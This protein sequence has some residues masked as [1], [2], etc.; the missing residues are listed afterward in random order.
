M[1]LKPILIASLLLICIC[2]AQTTRA[3][4][5][6]LNLRD[7]GAVGDGVADDGPALQAALDALAAGGG[8][9]LFVPEGHYAIITPVAKDF[10]GASSITIFGVE[11]STPV[12]INGGGEE[13][14]SGLDLVSEFLPQTG[15]EVI[16]VSISGVRTFLIHDLAFVGNPNVES[17]ALVTLDLARIDSATISHCEFYGLCTINSGGAIVRAVR[18]VLKLEH[19]KFL[20]STG[21]SGLYAPVV[22]NLHWKGISVT[23]CVF[24]DYG[25]RPDQWGKLGDSTPLSWI[26]IGN[27]D[28][29]TNDSPRREVS[30][31][32]V[33][34]DEGAYIG[35]TVNPDFY[36]PS[37]PVDLFYVSGLRM[38]VSNLG[39]A[40]NY[41]GGIQGMLIE[42][43]TYGRNQNASSAVYIANV[44][45]AIL[46]RLACTDAASTIFAD[47]ATDKLTVIDSVYDDLN[48]QAQSTTIINSTTPDGDPVAYVRSRYQST[49][50]HG[51]DAAGHYYWS[52][53]ILSCGDDAQCIAARHA[54]LQAFL[55]SSPA[56]T[57]SISGQV[58]DEQGAP[59]AGVMV[60]L[61]GSQAVSTQTNADGRYVFSNLPT[62]G[63]YTV[64]PSANYGF[65]VPAVTVVTPAGDETVDFMA[66]ANGYAISGRVTNASGDGIAGAN[67]NLSGGQN[68]ATISDANGSYS[69]TGL[70]AG[71]DYSVAVSRVNYSFLPDTLSFVQLQSNQ[72]ANFAGAVVNYTIGGR[73]TKNGYPF[74]NAT[75]TMS[76][77]QN[78]FVKTDATGQYSFNVP[79]EQSYLITPSD[80]NYTFAPSS[81]AISNLSSNQTADFS[82]Q[83]NWGAPVLISEENSTR[84]IALD[85]VLNTTE[86]FDLTYALPW[87]TD[88]RT[89]L[90]VF[91]NNFELLPNEN[92]AAITADVQDAQ[93]HIYNL[94]VE[95]IDSP[96]GMDW[97]NRIVL[98]LPDDLGDVGDV[99][100]RITY[101]GVSSN[102]VRVAIDHV[103]GGPPDD[104][105]AVP[106]P[107]T[108]PN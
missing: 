98:R 42:N 85:C 76:G 44:R 92:V 61:S 94:T 72:T 22:E 63:V 33:F 68:A 19:S 52:E 65:N 34:L 46:D 74:V 23:N 86:P 45:Q 78:F 14:S 101:H 1:R 105:G 25:G 82:A 9:S 37:A 71:K 38:N 66:I 36:P 95:Y 83:I 35:I 32:D 102:R 27:A 12:N 17:D 3:Q 4:T 70:T 15:A 90:K 47:G 103:G 7:F 40:G 24:S 96:S 41:I 54:L 31:R 58:T 11:S 49:L 99:L 28:A 48:S 57:F 106:T 84:A 62:S 91:A 79:A 93:G 51:P 29:V 107:G 108:V 60:T 20:G 5:A 43:G 56:E 16:A 89:R 88:N 18:S 77:G 100:L 67:I 26:N 30:V 97:L 75:V 80:P 59:V 55:G 87:G 39:S 2:W 50:G 21:N 73:I 81:A 8:G 104:P 13:L 10:G 53:S 64:T 6:N 69:F